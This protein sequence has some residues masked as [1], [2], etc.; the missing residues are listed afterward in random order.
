[1][2]VDGIDDR[3]AGESDEEDYHPPK[4]RRVLS[5]DEDDVGRSVSEGGRQGGNEKREG[6]GG[7]DEEGDD[8]EDD[9]D[10]S[11]V[12]SSTSQRREQ[13]DAGETRKEGGG[14]DDPDEPE[15][16]DGAESRA[17]AAPMRIHRG[18]AGL[19]AALDAAARHEDKPG[20]QSKKVK[21][22]LQ[23]EQEGSV[24]FRVVTNDGSAE[25]MILLTGLKNVFQTQLP[26]MPKEYIARLVYD[27][28]HYSMAIVR[29]P[30]R[31]VGG[32]TYRPFPTRNFAEIVFLAVVSTEQVQG[33]GSRLMAHFKD[34]IRA[35]YDIKH[36]LTY[37]DNFAT[38]Y[39]RKQGFTVEITLDKA[40]WMGYIKDYEGGTIMQCSMVNKVKYLEARNIVRAQKRAVYE[41]IR[42]HSKSHIVHPGL[43]AF[44]NGV[45]RV[46]PAT[47]P[48]LA[49]AGW[50]PD[51]E[52]QMRK[53]PVKKRGPLYRAMK[54]LTSEMFDHDSAWPFRCPVTHVPDYHEVIKEPMDLRTLG[55]KVEEDAYKTLEE[56]CRDVNLI[57]SNCRTYNLETSI[58][59]KCTRMVEKF[60][61]ERLKQIKSEYGVE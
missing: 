30:L 21:K 44:K 55:E 58:Y 24:E 23:E 51:M 42:Q 1:M 6:A 7:G 26:Q 19:P 10:E 37:A 13:G 39:F 33:F 20:D 31:V 8:E 54:A 57:F 50:T 47:I 49:E 22:A 32:I 27:R 52:E 18:G 59:W 61:K 46:D 3:A 40:V 53:R 28:N 56:Y 14:D 45:A 15:D 5:S 35:A 2:V 43:E 11:G 4:R 41:K 25:S 12:K 60:F 17:A 29:P 9:E 36:F 48:G 16:E 38:G 34:H